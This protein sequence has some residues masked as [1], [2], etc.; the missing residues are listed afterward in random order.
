MYGFK[1]VLLYNA[2]KE[3][4]LTFPVVPAQ[5]VNTNKSAKF[6]GTKTG[7]KTFLVTAYTVMSLKHGFKS[8]D[9]VFK[10]WFTQKQKF[11]H[12]LLILMPMESWVQLLHSERDLNKCLSKCHF[13]VGNVYEHAMTLNYGADLMVVFSQTPWE[14]GLFKLRMLFKDDYPSSPPKCELLCLT[15]FQRKR[16]YYSDIHTSE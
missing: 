6:S 16:N 13:F 9:K 7:V 4:C 15:R 1:Y 5:V 12:Y 10:K 14:G 11:T 8:N 3:E 2:T